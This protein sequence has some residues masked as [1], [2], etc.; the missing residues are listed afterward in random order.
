M[1]NLVYGIRWTDIADVIVA[2]VLVNA[3]A[4]AKIAGVLWM[5]GGL[6][7][8][9]VLRWTGRSTDLPVES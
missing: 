8:F 2:T 6:V 3:E 1:L 7:L 4:N 5:I 9:L